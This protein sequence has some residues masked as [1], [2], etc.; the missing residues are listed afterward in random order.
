MTGNIIIVVGLIIGAFFVGWFTAKHRIMKKMME[1][2]E[3]DMDNY[4]LQLISLL[5]KIEKGLK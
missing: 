5:R 4:R 2:F 1:A 3:R